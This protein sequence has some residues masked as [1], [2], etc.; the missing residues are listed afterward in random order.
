MKRTAFSSFLWVLSIPI[1][2]FFKVLYEWKIESG[3]ET[4]VAKPYPISWLDESFPYNIII[5]IVLLLIST[6]MSFTYIKAYVRP[7]YNYE[8]ALFYSLS[9]L[10]VLVPEH[11]T[12]F[13]GLGFSMNAVLQLFGLLE[14]KTGAFILFDVGLIVGIAILFDLY[15]SF[16]A[17]GIFLFLIVIGR[18]AREC[19]Q[20]IIGFSL[21]FLFTFPFLYSQELVLE[22]QYYFQDFLQFHLLIKELSVSDVIMLVLLIL[23]ATRHSFRIFSKEFVKP[24]ERNF[25]IF[26]FFYFLISLLIGILFFA[27]TKQFLLWVIPSLTILY[28]LGKKQHPIIFLCQLLLIA[29]YSFLM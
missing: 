4:L 28:S 26:I 20:Y 9:T 6:F 1:F 11:T 19:L 24:Y 12:L 15:I 2:T 23:F 7:Q 29:L 5:G 22:W 27:N 13:I 17:I 25:F 10:I 16:L 14:K 21:P 8:V 18:S 3:G